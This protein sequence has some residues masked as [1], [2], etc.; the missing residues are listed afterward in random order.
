VAPSMVSTAASAV[1]D[2][3]S[4][5]RWRSVIGVDGFT[6]ARYGAASDLCEST[7]LAGDKVGNATVEK[8][9]AARKHAREVHS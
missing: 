6:C 2:V 7:N 4:E 5:R 8:S 9:Q 1:N 3:P